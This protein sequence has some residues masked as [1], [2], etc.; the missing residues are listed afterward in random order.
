MPIILNWKITD[1]H[2]IFKLNILFPLTYLGALDS[3][4]NMVDDL[5]REIIRHLQGDVPL[6]LTPFATVADKL[7][8]DE[9][10]LLERIR[11]L[12]ERGVLRRFGATVNHR[13][14]GFKA[15]A[16]VAWY[17]PEDKVDEVGP[18]MASMKEVSHCYQRE[19][20][21]E[22][23][24]NLFTMIHGKSK[25]ECRDIVKRM[26]DKTGM[27]DYSILFTLKEYKRASPEYY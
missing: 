16:M 20:Q 24:Y 11:S 7:G 17:V 8:I 1:F 18:L 5:E 10:E 14:V 15:N 19:V 2:S 25:K 12:K 27:R 26:V 22:W 4:I 3:A 23:R 13:R 21:G 6:T 9:E